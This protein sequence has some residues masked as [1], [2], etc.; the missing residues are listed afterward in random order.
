MAGAQK[1]SLERRNFLQFAAGG[2]AALVTSAQ[3][4]EAQQTESANAGGDNPYTRG[5]ADSRQHA[6][7]SRR[8]PSYGQPVHYFC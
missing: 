5:M 7:L 6:G 8:T 2:A 1:G 4:A 3:R